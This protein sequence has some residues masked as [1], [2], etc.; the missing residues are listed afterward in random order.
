MEIE[1]TKYYSEDEN[2]QNLEVTTI[3]NNLLQITNWYTIINEGPW[4]LELSKS[5]HISQSSSKSY[6]ENE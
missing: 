4:Y 1:K 2:S 3:K 5:S 6:F